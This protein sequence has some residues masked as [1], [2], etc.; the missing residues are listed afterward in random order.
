MPPLRPTPLN[1]ILSNIDASRIFL[2]PA[3]AQFSTLLKWS[4]TRST[5]TGLQ[6]V[7]SMIDAV[8]ETGREATDESTAQIPIHFDDYLPKWNYVARPQIL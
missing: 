7:T 8:Y 1:T 6:V 2:E 3:K 4:I 5:K